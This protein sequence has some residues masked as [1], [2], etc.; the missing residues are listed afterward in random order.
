[1][2][3]HCAGPYANF[4]PLADL[5][6]SVVADAGIAA[7][8]ATAAE[9]GAAGLLPFG[10]ARASAAAAAADAPGSSKGHVP[11]KVALG[12]MLLPDYIQT[13]ALNRWAGGCH[14]QSKRRICQLPV[15][16]LRGTFSY[17][18]L[19]KACLT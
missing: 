4:G 10:P 8:G 3:C 7:P 9:G 18:S 5:V 1:V 11:H 12:Y 17:S 2:C 15:E 14:V 16:R 6:D 13:A 19:E